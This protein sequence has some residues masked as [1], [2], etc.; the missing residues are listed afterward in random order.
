MYYRNSVLFFENDMVREIPCDKKVYISSDFK[1][2][3]KEKNIGHLTCYNENNIVILNIEQKK[4]ELKPY[5]KYVYDNKKIYQL[6]I[7]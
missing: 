7:L 4:I 5:E 6:F 1:V 2:G 3:T